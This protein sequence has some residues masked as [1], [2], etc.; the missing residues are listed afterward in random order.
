MIASDNVE[1][2]V[3]ISSISLPA[4]F[5]YSA[6]PKL[7]SNAYLKAKALNSGNYPFLEG[8]ANVYRD[9]S[10]VAT[11]TLE[12]VPPG[13]SFWVFLGADENMKV[14][15]KLIKHY[16]SHQ[17]LRNRT[18][19]HMYEYLITVKNTHAVAEEFII[20][21]QLPISGNEDLKVKLIK[22]KY[23]KDTDS[24]RIDDE[25]RIQWF[26]T[27]QPGQELKLPFHFYVEAPRNE[28]I[29]GLE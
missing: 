3:A 2:R 17:G 1:H 16:Q 14:E 6:V 8:K 23:S 9:G 7:D 22:P 21:D 4:H 24:L 11:S 13:E 15:H 12:L 10:Y 20:W 5:R 29:S 26:Q 28:E 25:R 19:R 27:L 18:V